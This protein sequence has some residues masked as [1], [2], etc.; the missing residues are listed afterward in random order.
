MKTKKRHA[1]EFISKQEF[2]QR[3]K[4]HY[5]SFKKGFRRKYKK[6]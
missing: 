5:E 2:F 4:K 6:I 3:E 1:V